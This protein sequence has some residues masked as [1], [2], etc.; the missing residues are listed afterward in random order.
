MKTYF[1]HAHFP[2][3]FTSHTFIAEKPLEDVLY[4][5]KDEDIGNWVSVTG[6]E[7]KEV[8]HESKGKFMITAVQGAHT[9]QSSP[10]RPNQKDKGS[11]KISRERKI[12]LIHYL[13]GSD[14]QNIVLRDFTE[15]LEDLRLIRF[16]KK[17]RKTKY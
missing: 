14:L 6:E 3:I 5:K 12:E 4:Q 8:Q 16:L 7:Q 13:R 2:K 15:I 9:D 10:H 17:L 11:R 1:C